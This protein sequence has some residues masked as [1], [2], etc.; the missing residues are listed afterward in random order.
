[1]HSW[2]PFMWWELWIRPR[3]PCCFRANILLRKRAPNHTLTNKLAKPRFKLRFL[4]PR[5]Y[6]FKSSL[7]VSSTSPAS[8]SLLE[9]FLTYILLVLWTS[10][11]KQL[12]KL[13]AVSF[14]PGPCD[15]PALSLENYSREDGWIKEVRHPATPPPTASAAL[16]PKSVRLSPLPPLMAEVSHL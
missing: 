1:M 7:E 4:D 2:V 15:P 3:G 14:D 16:F 11:S 10:P 12:H 13:R 5:T 9:R 8:S 6:T